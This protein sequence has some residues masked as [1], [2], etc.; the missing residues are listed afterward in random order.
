MQIPQSL[1][2]FY[3]MDQKYRV[4]FQKFQLSK[5]SMLH[6]TFHSSQHLQYKF[7]RLLLVEQVIARLSNYFSPAIKRCRYAALSGPQYEFHINSRNTTSCTTC[8]RMLQKQSFCSA[9]KVYEKYEERNDTAIL[10]RS[11]HSKCC[12]K[13]ISD[14][15]PESYGC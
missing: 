6:F 4:N 8:F 12:H 2:L 13:A 7:E 5:N 9:C 1:P 14:C 10:I 3:F 15:R 11:R